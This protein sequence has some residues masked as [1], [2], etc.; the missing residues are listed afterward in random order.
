MDLR[1]ISN[2]ALRY[3]TPDTT[4]RFQIKKSNGNFFSTQATN[5]SGVRL[6]GAVQTSAPIE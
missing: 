1:R 4:L 5:P 2:G 3:S 6:A